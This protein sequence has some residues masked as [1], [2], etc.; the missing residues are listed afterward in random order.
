LVLA[1][2]YGRVYR[3]Y[4]TTKLYQTNSITNTN[5]IVKNLIPKLKSQTQQTQTQAQTQTHF[6]SRS[7]EIS[8]DPATTVQEITRSGNNSTRKVEN[9][10]IGLGMLASSRG[11]ACPQPWR[12]LRPVRLPTQA[13]SSA[14]AEADSTPFASFVF[15]LGRDMVTERE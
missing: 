9:K 4:K 2:G 6:L 12:R 15:L 1:G 7:S 13:T 14:Q 10:Q 11:V 5:K 8:L 3:V